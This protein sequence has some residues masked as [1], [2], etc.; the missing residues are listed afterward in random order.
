MNRIQP[1]LDEL[2]SALPR[3]VTPPSELWP[4][5]AAGA[6]RRTRSAWFMN[7]YD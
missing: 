2:L 5:I 4:G 3:E 1:Q 7:A 6:R